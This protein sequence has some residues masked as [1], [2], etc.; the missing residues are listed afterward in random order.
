MN[1]FFE[2]LRFKNKKAHLLEKPEHKW[3]A[4]NRDI[5]DVF[6][7]LSNIGLKYRNLN[8]LLETTVFINSSGQYACA[9][10]ADVNIIIIYPELCFLMGNRRKEQALAILLHELAHLILEHQKNGI[11]NDKAQVEADLFSAQLGYGEELLLFLL[12]QVQTSQV[13]MRVSALRRFL[14][15][16][17]RASAQS[18]QN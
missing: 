17:E 5:A 13:E 8:E 2:K 4:E 18:L 11:E 14:N 9:I 10:K 16:K 7:E 6:S 3:I 15:I 12:G 1:N